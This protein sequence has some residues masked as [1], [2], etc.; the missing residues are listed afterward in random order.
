MATVQAPDTAIG[1]QLLDALRRRDYIGIS[2]CFAEGAQLRAVVPPG[3]REDD[4][5][6]AIAARFRLWTGE[7]GDYELIDGVVDRF[8]DLL[9]I[10]YAVRE[11]ST[12]SSGSARSSRPPT[13][14]SP[15]GASRSSGS[16][17]PASGLW[18]SGPTQPINPRS[19]PAP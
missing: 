9:R 17:A 18:R 14:R 16:R 5:P 6:D 13:P 8:E 2:S 7:Y 12:R 3:V 10:R 19:I 11:A 1:T 4:G 15:T